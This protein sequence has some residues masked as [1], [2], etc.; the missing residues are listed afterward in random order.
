MTAYVLNMLKFISPIFRFK[1]PGHGRW[2]FYWW[3]LEQAV[4]NSRQKQM[5]IIFSKQAHDSTEEDRTIWGFLV[6]VRTTIFRDIL[7]SSK[8]LMVR[9][10]RMLITVKSGAQET[11]V[12]WFLVVINVLLLFC[13][14]H[15]VPQFALYIYSILFN[16]F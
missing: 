5:N 11:V 8:S 10:Y 13:S 7:D 14:A 3:N 6:R 15:N 4:G 1:N 16:I 9:T 2:F 12:V